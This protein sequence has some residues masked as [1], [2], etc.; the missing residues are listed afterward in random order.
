MTASRPP[1]DGPHQRGLGPWL[2][3]AAGLVLAA[4]LAVW[5]LSVRDR[6]GDPQPAPTSSSDTT[7]SS[8]A[9][10]SSDTASSSDAAPL[11]SRVGPRSPAPD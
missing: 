4:A 6:G 8:D 3:L 10:S 9:T 11:L 5:A 7:S 2:A 1:Q